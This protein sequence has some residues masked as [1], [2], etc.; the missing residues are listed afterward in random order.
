MQHTIATKIAEVL[1]D[2]TETDQDKILLIYG[3]ETILNDILKDIMCVMISIL[4]GCWQIVIF[5]I[6]SLKVLR[7]YGGGYHFKKNTICWIASLSSVF[8]MALFGK[9]FILPIFFKFILV[10]IEGGIIIAYA[11]KKNR[12]KIKSEK[13]I[14]KYATFIIFMLSISIGWMLGGN[15]YFNSTIVAGGVF[16]ALLVEIPFI[17]CMSEGK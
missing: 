5:N 12:I 16:A 11:P 17:K 10:I 4:L 8:P 15:Y 13:Y 7:K 6:L 3:I 2:G 14:Y 1:E 9:N